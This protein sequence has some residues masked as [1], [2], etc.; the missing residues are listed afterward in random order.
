MHEVKPCGGLEEV[1]VAGFDAGLAVSGCFGEDGRA[2]GWGFN[3][4]YQLA[5]GDDMDDVPLP[6]KIKET[7][8]FN[9][10]KVV[11]M[12]FGGQHTA[13]LCVPREDATEAAPPAKKA[14]V[15]PAPAAE[16]VPP[17]PASLPPLPPDMD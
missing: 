13:L 1:A 11:Q 10:Q 16:A 9:G 4:S 8:A 3:D 5:K 7:K 6:E 2:Y 17:A 14:K 12:S 15:D